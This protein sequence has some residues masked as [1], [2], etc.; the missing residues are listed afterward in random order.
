MVKLRT[1]I[2]VISIA[3]SCVSF[4]ANTLF[5]KTFGATAEVDLILRCAAV[6][7]GISGVLSGF[8]VYALPVTFCQIPNSEQNIIVIHLVKKLTQIIA[9]AA[10]LLLVLYPTSYFISGLLFGFYL[11]L[12]MVYI[13]LSVGNASAQSQGKYL[14]SSVISASNSLGLLVGVT[15]AKSSGKPILIVLGQIL[16][17]LFGTTVLIKSLKIKYTSDPISSSTKIAIK[18]LRKNAHF[19][20]IAACGFSAYQTVDSVMSLLLPDGAL[21]YMSYG[22]K[23]IASANTVLGFGILTIGARKA[24]DRFSIGGEII[25]LKS[26][27][28]ESIIIL[29]CG[30]CLWVGF[31]VF[32]CRVVKV[33]FLSDRFDQNHVNVLYK[34]SKWMFLALGPVTALSHHYQVYYTL[35]NYKKP[36]VLGV[37]LILSYLTII[38]LNAE[39][40]QIVAPAYA[41]AVSWWI[42]ILISFVFLNCRRL[43]K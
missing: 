32:G 19:I 4:V 33:M 6:P 8:F 34:C 31:S 27:N 9:V 22:Q 24:R 28:H 1:L 35:G 43:S 10:V 5:L 25:L 39:E 3:S 38:F 11:F 12:S 26:A 23:L 2:T 37:V 36:A 13:V 20:I 41:F 14:T 40:Y 30:L 29:I 21:V 15:L 18:K 17:A 42:T 7:L 16:G